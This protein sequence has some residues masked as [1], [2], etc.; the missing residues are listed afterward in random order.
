M[1]KYF[2]ILIT[3]LAVLSI[4]FVGCKNKPTAVADFIDEPEA[5]TGSVTPTPTKKPLPDNINFQEYSG[6]SFMSKDYYYKSNNVDKKFQYTIKIK[7]S[8]FTNGGT[9]AEF[10]GYE[11]G[12]EFTRTYTGTTRNYKKEF[13]L[14]KVSGSGADRADISFN[15]NEGYAYFKPS[16]YNFTIELAATNKE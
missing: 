2:Y 14:I 15:I 8:E 9:V 10:K 12:T 4:G 16:D 3:L 13:P 11:N 5:P 7:K 6:Y 1:R